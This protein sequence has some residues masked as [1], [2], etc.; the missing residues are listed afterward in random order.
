MT[1]LRRLAAGGERFMRVTGPAATAVGALG[2]VLAASAAARPAAPDPGIAGTT[3]KGMTGT[4]SA[5]AAPGASILLVETPVAETE[6]T[7]GFPQIVAAEQYVLKHHLGNVISQ[8]FG[9]TEATFASAKAVQALRGAYQLAS[10]DHVTV[11][12]ASGD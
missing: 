12:A 10:T 8:S 11:L 9:A 2:L 1:G 4:D 6:G 5:A 7:H 3:V